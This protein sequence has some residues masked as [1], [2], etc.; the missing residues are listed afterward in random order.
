MAPSKFHLILRRRLRA[1]ARRRRPLSCFAA[2]R[3]ALR[4]FA[5][6]LREPTASQGRRQCHALFP[7]AVPAALRS[8]S[9]APQ[10]GGFLGPAPRAAP[11]LVPQLRK[12]SGLHNAPAFVLLRGPRNPPVSSA[13]TGT[14]GFQEPTRKPRLV[15]LRS[16][17]SPWPL[18]CNM[19]GLPG[20]SP[21]QTRQSL[22]YVGD[23]PVAFHRIPEITLCFSQ[24]IFHIFASLFHRPVV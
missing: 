11:C 13:A 16:P 6:R 20:R 23:S 10:A 22:L 4:R 12:P 17:G 7:F 2:S 9:T 3:T 1:H 5:S 24:K 14:G 19:P 15:S 21:G 18:P 8:A